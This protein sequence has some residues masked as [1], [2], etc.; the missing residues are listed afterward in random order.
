MASRALGVIFT[1]NPD[2]QNGTGISMHASTKTWMAMPLAALLLWETAG[3]SPT[4]TLDS[5]RDLDNRPAN[6]LSTTQTVVLIFLANQCPLSNRSIPEIQRLVEKY[7]TREVRFWIVH[8]NRDESL[9]A[10]RAHAQE[11][12]LD[13]TVIRDPDHQLVRFAQA[14]V[15]PEAA[16][17][18][19]H[20][21]LLYR[22]KIDNRAIA[23]GRENAIVTQHHLDDAL[24]LIL[25]GS[26]ARVTNCPAVGCSIPDL[27]E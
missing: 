6:P 24:A 12:K 18:D 25:A 4:G 2:A 3:C 19:R 10:V 20:K 14:S 16:V 5:V 11:F 23:L 26:A 8:P 1:W 15:T 22:G 9:E 13:A 17:F 27:H 7:A 21:Q